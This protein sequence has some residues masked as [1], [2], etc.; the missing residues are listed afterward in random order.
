MA[1]LGLNPCFLQSTGFPIANASNI[2]LP[3]GVTDIQPNIYLYQSYNV[4]WT[5]ITAI[6]DAAG[7]I[8]TVNTSGQVASYS[9]SNC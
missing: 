1:Q 9:T 7:N 4:K 3:L 8:Y 2:Y 5:N 6:A